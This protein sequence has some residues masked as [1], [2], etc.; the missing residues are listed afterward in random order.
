[1]ATKAATEFSNAVILARTV[2]I[3]DPVMSVV[4]TPRINELEELLT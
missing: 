3:A 2:L 1:M 4:D